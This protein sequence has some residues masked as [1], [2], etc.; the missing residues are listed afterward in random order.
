MVASAPTLTKAV[1]INDNYN[2]SSGNIIACSLTVNAGKILTVNNPA[3]AQVQNDVNV[4]GEIF[5]ETQGAFVQIDNAGTFNLIGTGIASVN[6]QTPAKAQ[7]YYYTYWSSPV[8]NET[9]E[10]LF[11]N[12]DVD[13]RY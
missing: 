5:V 2:T 11:P 3:V 1:I 7:W 12:V 6:K 9:I 8:A 13:R 10:N 4:S